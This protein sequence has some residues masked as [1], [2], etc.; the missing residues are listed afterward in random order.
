MQPMAGT[1]FW[2]VPLGTFVAFMLVSMALEPSRHPALEHPI[3]R[4]IGTISY[5]LYLWHLWG[6]GL[7]ES[8]PGPKPLQ[9]LLGIVLAVFFATASYY[10][11]ER[12]VLR[13]RD[14]ASSARREDG[15]HLVSA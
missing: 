5:P 3:L 12:P 10:L 14:A 4:W 1:A 15:R 2:A 13:W 9:L 8:R 6:L 11:I 7:A